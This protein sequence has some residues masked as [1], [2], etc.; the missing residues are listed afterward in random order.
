MNTL[1]QHAQALVETS[2][3]EVAKNLREG[4]LSDA[5]VMHSIGSWYNQ[6]GI[7]HANLTILRV[8]TDEFIEHIISLYI[9]SS[10]SEVSIDICYPD[11][12]ILRSIGDFAFESLDEKAILTWFE[13][14][15]LTAKEGFL[16]YAADLK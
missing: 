6:N 11:G 4:L 8:N 3:H 2:L 5:F 9:I 10:K 14:T 15:C 1:L 13:A 16:K 7:L 12:S